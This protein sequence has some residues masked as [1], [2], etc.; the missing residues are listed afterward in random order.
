MSRR[1]LF[2]FVIL[3]F[4]SVVVTSPIEE[5]P[6]LDCP[7][8]ERYYKCS[9]EVCFKTCDHLKRNPPC[10]AISS[11]CFQPSCECEMSYLR[12]SNGVCVPY[13]EC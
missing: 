8:N 5:A 1:L 7:E 9:L 11:D 10:P 12:N 4:V 2:V 3:C 6:P 13:E